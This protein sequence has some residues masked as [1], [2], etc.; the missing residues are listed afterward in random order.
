MSGT[1]FNL[2]YCYTRSTRK[3]KKNR[4]CIDRSPLLRHLNFFCQKRFSKLHSHYVSYDTVTLQPLLLHI[5]IVRENN[6]NN[7][8]SNRIEI[9][10]ETI[11]GSRRANRG[12]CFTRCQ[13]KL[14]P[15]QRCGSFCW[16]SPSRNAWLNSVTEALLGL[17]VELN[18]VC[19][20][21]RRVRKNSEP[22]LENRKRKKMRDSLEEEDKAFACV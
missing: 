4:I 10:P 5:M 13:T 20:L 7:N 2:R 1:V 15:H 22:N 3:K 8:Y 12:L 18:F 21:S 16:R 11:K 9:K 6:C 19:S 14:L 17:S